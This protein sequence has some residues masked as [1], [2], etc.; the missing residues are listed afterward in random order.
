[1]SLG[2][3]F[4]SASPRNNGINKGKLDSA[5]KYKTTKMLVKIKPYKKRCLPILQCLYFGIKIN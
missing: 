1:M 4:I 2:P 3:E 5:H